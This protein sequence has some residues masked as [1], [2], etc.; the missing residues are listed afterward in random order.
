MKRLRL[1][2]RMLPESDR[3]AVAEDLV[4]MPVLS[5][6]LTGSDNPRG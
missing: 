2:F 3:H 6:S 5:V 4:E 1:E